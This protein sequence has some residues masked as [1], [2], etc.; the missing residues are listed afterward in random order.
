MPSKRILFR[1]YL[2]T[3]LIALVLAVIVVLRAGDA[4][5]LVTIGTRFS[6]GLSE[7]AGGT[8][9][10]DGQFNYY[11]AR[12]LSGAAPF[13]DVP[14]YRMQRILFP[15]LGALLSFGQE[16]GIVWAFL[17][18]NL[19]AIA[20]GVA[21]LENLL[22][23]HKANRW[24]SLGFG[25]S[26]GI[27]GS[28]RLSLSEPLAYALVLAALWQSTRE[29][30]LP[31][32][33]LLALAALAKETTLFFAAGW[34]LYVLAIERRPLRAVRIGSISLLPF[35]LWQFVLRAHFGTFGIGSGG[36]QA[37]PFEI[38]P[39]AGIVR[40][41]TES[42]VASW[43]GLA[44][45]YG[46]ILIPFV[47]LPTLWALRQVWQDGRKRT[48]TFWSALLLANALILP[49]VPFSTYRE[50][51]GILRF[52]LG[53]QIA[54]ILYAAA[55]RHPRALRYSTFW[56]LTGLFALTLMGS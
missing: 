3:T 56:A 1:P 38:I 46:A 9:G 30:W 6:E 22:I 44:L 12:D 26:L 49:F 7:A 4:H 54:L 20:G 48:F 13:L 45:I 16:N 25:L 11:I 18:I 27:I 36:E 15:A 2:L 23:G 52:I 37:T 43:A 31:G 10:Y 51:I 5:A 40:I 33:L 17:L 19:I 53:L 8:E 41:F 42:P 21:L 14:A 28:A 29:R 50:P 24:L 39:F 47:L 32:A 55:G 34:V 35:V